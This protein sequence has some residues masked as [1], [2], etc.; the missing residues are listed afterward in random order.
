[1]DIS[2]WME[3]VVDLFI[4]TN[5]IYAAAVVVFFTV[6]FWML[7]TPLLNISEKRFPSVTETLARLLVVFFALSSISYFAFEKRN[8]LVDDAYAEASSNYRISVQALKSEA[9]KEADIRCKHIDPVLFER[10]LSEAKAAAHSA[11]CSAVSELSGQIRRINPNNFETEFG[12]NADIFEKYRMY[13]STPMELMFKSYMNKI[14]SIGQDRATLHKLY[15]SKVENDKLSSFTIAVLI[16]ASV[17]AAIQLSLG[18]K[19]P[20]R[21]VFGFVRRMLAFPFRFLGG[22]LRLV[23]RRETQPTSQPS[24]GESKSERNPNHPSSTLK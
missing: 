7:F 16:L 3:W 18:T 20:N 23:F 10:G 24:E 14:A 22:A 15:L 4:T 13:T 9:S 8:V 1:M 19:F 5:P 2:I 11:A 12:V 6:I 21:I 17:A